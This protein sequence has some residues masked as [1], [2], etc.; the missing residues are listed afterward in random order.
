LPEFDTDQ[1]IDLI[2][3][4]FNKG[5]ACNISKWEGF[6]DVLGQY[7]ARN[8]SVIYSFESFG[9][10]DF[11]VEANK[12]RFLSLTE[13]WDVEIIVTYRHYH[14]WVPSLYY[15]M[16][17]FLVMMDDKGVLWPEDGGFDMPSFPDSFDDRFEKPLSDTMEFLYSTNSLTVYRTFLQM[18]DNVSVI[19]VNDGSLSEKW[20]CSLEGADDACDKVSR[21]Q[22]PKVTEDEDAD[23]M[24]KIMFDLVAVAA[25][26]DAFVDPFL[27]RD[28]V[29]NEAQTF[30]K[31]LGADYSLPLKCLSPLQEQEFFE[32]SAKLNEVMPVNSTVEDTF[33]LAKLNNEFCS[34]DAGKVLNDT[35]WID[36]FR[37]LSETPEIS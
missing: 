24:S 15:E 35:R 18:F 1:S 6:V 9:T 2:V 25:R 13:D 32:L 27:G 11:V 14:D 34:V 4:C 21:A 5:D 7:G 29:R 23:Y 3:D 19:D 30:A 8:N 20:I 12:K 22:V 37:D 31:T 10:V 28:F 17:K 26:K 36:F 33:S 16:Y